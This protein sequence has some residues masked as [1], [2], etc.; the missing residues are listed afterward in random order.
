MKNCYQFKNQNMIEHGLLVR[1]HHKQI[2]KDLHH[3]TNQYELPDEL[4]AHSKQFL[5]HQ[6]NNHILSYYQLYHDCGKP[7]CLE[8]DDDG[9]RRYPKHEE[10][11]AKVFSDAF[12]KTKHCDK[13]STL[14][15][16]DMIFH[17]E[18]MTDIDAFLE[19]CDDKRLVYSLILTSFAELYANKSMFDD[20]NQTSFKIK[21]KKLHRVVKKIIKHHE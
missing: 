5:K 14:I 19:A 6:Y 8:I 10:V 18:N 13:I 2:I 1:K 21:Y 16:N 4:R 17:K 3:S 12:S 9:K 7:F 11:S 20:N 15:A